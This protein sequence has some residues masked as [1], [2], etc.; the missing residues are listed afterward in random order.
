LT[1]LPTDSRERR[2]HPR[3]GLSQA[4]RIR[5]F[6]PNLPEYCNLLNGSR[7]GLYFSTDSNHYVLGMSVHVTT[8]F[9]PDSLLNTTFVGVVVRIDK[10]KCLGCPAG[11]EIFLAA[12]GSMDV[13][14]AIPDVYDESSTICTEI[15]YSLGRCIVTCRD[16]D[17]CNPKRAPIG[18]CGKHEAFD[19]RDMS[20]PVAVWAGRS[21]AHRRQIPPMLPDY[22]SR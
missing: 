1:Q 2:R 16:S 21:T 3:I 19:L 6:D 9:H 7:D 11:G 17:R 14:I 15:F 22:V 8:D 10:L 4:T 13:R 5:P 12:E 18:D 20:V